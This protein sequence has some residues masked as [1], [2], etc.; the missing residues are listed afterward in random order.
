MRTAR[1]SANTGALRSYVPGVPALEINQPRSWLANPDSFGKERSPELKKPR[2]GSAQDV[3]DLRAAMVHHACVL[4]VNDERRVREK[5]W[6]EVAADLH[7]VSYSQL[8]R[9]VTGQAHLS[10][11]LLSDLTQHFGPILVYSR[12]VRD[13]LGADTD[14][15]GLRSS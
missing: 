5:G 3:I 1:Q 13:V 14:W 12:H 6:Q 10:L 15:P 2:P 11:R 4:T 8:R 9:V 7:T